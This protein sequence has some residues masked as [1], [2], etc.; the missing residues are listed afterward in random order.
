[1]P[2]SD[3]APGNCS[4]KACVISGDA[5]ENAPSALRRLLAAPWLTDLQNADSQ[6]DETIRRVLPTDDEAI[7]GQLM[8]LHDGKVPESAVGISAKVTG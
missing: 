5:T 8:E 4:E 2:P 7:I 6:D 1:M 3:D